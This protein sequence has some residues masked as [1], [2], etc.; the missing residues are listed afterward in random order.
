MIVGIYIKANNSGELKEPI[1]LKIPIVALP[2][3]KTVKGPL[4]NPKGATIINST[5]S[6][7]ALL[8]IKPPI[9]DWKNGAA[10]PRNLI[11]HWQD[12]QETK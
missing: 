3:P 8:G 4:N 9:I 5:Q 6:N 11:E 7:N 10:I 12:K 2:A 1:A